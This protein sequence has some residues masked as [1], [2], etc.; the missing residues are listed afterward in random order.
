MYKKVC[1]V[2]KK[3]WV[4]L[5][6]SVQMLMMKNQGNVRQ[7]NVSSVASRVEIYGGDGEGAAGDVILGNFIEK[8]VPELFDEEGLRQ[9]SGGLITKLLARM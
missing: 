4:P 8:L 1:L 5:D 9:E 6:Y 2:L 3:M 7:E